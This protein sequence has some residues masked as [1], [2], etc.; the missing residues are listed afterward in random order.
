MPG[1]LGLNNSK[2]QT[3]TAQLDRD[4]LVP[5]CSWGIWRLS[6][7]HLKQTWSQLELSK[8]TWAVQAVANWMPVVGDLCFPWTR[9]PSS[10]LSSFVSLNASPPWSSTIYY[11]HLKD[12]QKRGRSRKNHRARRHKQKL[13]VP[14]RCHQNN[15]ACTR[16]RGTVGTAIFLET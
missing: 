8:P 9:S 7:N 12:L 2:R 14:Q 3:F 10:L 6:L 16:V 1:S 5:S 13:E 4:I 11:S 15:A